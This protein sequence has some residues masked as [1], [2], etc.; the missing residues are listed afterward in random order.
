MNKLNRYLILIIISS[1]LF[2]I[3]LDTTI[4]YTAL[5]KLSQELNMNS[6]EKIWSLNIYTVVVCAILPGAGALS[7]RFSSKKLFVIGMLVF[8]LA[9][10]VAGYAI[11]A[12]MLIIGR[13]LLG[14][15]AALMMPATLSLVRTTFIDEKERGFA[16]AVWGAIASF[17]SGIGPVAG[18]FI[19][20]NFYWG[21]IFLINIP[22]AITAIILGLKFIPKQPINKH[23]DFDLVGLIVAAITLLAFILGIKEITRV[24]GSLTLG[25]ILIIVSFIIGYIF[26]KHQTK[27]SNPIIDFSLFKN[28]K[29]RTGLVSIIL[30]SVVLV[31]TELMFTQRFQLI[32]N[33]S[34]LQTGLIL[35]S[36]ATA[37]LIS[38]LYLGTI[39][40]RLNIL[41]VQLVS[42]IIITLG[43]LPFIFFYNAPL[44]IQLIFLLVMGTGIGL[45]MIAGP[46][47]VI[48]NAPEEKA[49]MAASIEEIG[50]ELGNSIGIASLGG[51]ATF[52]YTNKL[53]V[54]KIQVSNDVYD[55]LDLAMKESNNL[56][57]EHA[58]YLLK[59][60]FIAFD[61]SFVWVMIAAFITAVLGTIY[62]YLKLRRHSKKS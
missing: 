5:V 38:G 18:G 19:L 53:D 33:Y 28:I 14:V 10:I 9:S 22:I 4:M 43:V 12:M 37:S 60:A 50:F 30:S 44:F 57:L 34:A 6:S 39:I 13:A 2:L 42:F 47:A 24:G 29:F 31:G 8:A 54:S 32:N 26:Y 58:Q 49:G 17:G 56:S 3:V 59:Q 48:N 27:I 16:L 35:T 36:M 25:L 62:L 46:N 1:G 61:H 52:V 7:D 51:I 40:Y 41:R 11:D 23:I 55:S 20:N 45:A 21:Y 15:G